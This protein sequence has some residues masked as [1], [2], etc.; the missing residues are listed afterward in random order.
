MD[1][2][3]IV[4]CV[5]DD[6]TVLNALRSLLVKHLGPRHVVESATSGAEALEI[7]AEL[8]EQGKEL[9]VVISDYI[10]PGM[11]GDELLVQLHELSANTVNIML[12]GQSDLEGVKRAINGANLYRFLEKPFNN[13]DIVLTARS[14]AHAYAQGRELARQHAQLQHI[15]ENLEGLVQQRTAELAA[16]NDEV[17]HG[18]LKDGLT[19]LPNRQGLGEALG[20]ACARAAGEGAGFAVLLL[21]IDN[22]KQINGTH[23]HP[24]GD[25]VL[26]DLAGILS[27]NLGAADVLGRWGDEEFLIVMPGAGADGARTA[28]NTLRACLARQSLPV[29]G[30]MTACFGS[31]LWRGGDIVPALIA[32]AD[33]ALGRAKTGGRDRIEHGQ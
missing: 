1:Q 5:D 7:H 20:A 19:G 15:N 9:S 27:Q 2:A 18:A 21:D 29:V 30:K 25:Q 23:G 17:V 12:T 24:V 10:M 3:S 4:M 28:A 13:A 8:R 26:V 32:R 33:A 11:R 22:F 31:A 6:T 14:A 16:K